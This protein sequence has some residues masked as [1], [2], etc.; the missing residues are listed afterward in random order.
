MSD[1]TDSSA[2]A[3]P[4]NLSTM[5]NI[6]PTLQTLHQSFGSSLPVLRRQSD[7]Q[8]QGT[9]KWQ[10]RHELYPAWSAVEDAKNKAAKLSDAAVAEFDKASSKAQAKTGAIEL[11][12]AKYYAACTVGGIMACGLTHTAVTP[13]DLV[14]CRRQVDSK[15]YKGN[16]EA[17][18]KISRAEG[19]RGIY[20][21]WGPTLIGYSVQGG[22]KYGGY[23]FFK[24][25]YGDLVG[26][27]NFHKYK[28]V[29]YL[30][31]SASA[32]FIADIGLCPF[33]AVKVRMQTTIPPFAKT[34]MG[35]IS[36]ITS[37]EGFGGS[38]HQALQCFF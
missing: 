28:T 23:E 31:G 12:S 13:L 26:E 2:E 35:G 30:A 15:M 25:F 10:A 24:K 11:Y 21:G 17:W 32:E 27:D 19:F 37:K 3:P 5:Q 16:F 8:S 34:T 20:T 33:E 22:F 6:F 9:S 1:P 18:G 29:I 36:Y 4:A 38:V 7:S 14:K